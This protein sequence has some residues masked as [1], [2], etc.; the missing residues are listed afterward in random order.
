[1]AERRLN[2]KLVLLGESAVGKSSIVLRFVKSQ[3]SEY[4]E[5][6]IG[7]CVF[8]RVSV[9]GQERYH[10]LAPMYCRNAQAAIIVYD[11]TNL[12][13]FERAK[14]WVHELNERANSVKVLALAGNKL[15]L[16]S[17]RAVTTEQAQAYAT[18][19]GL[20]FMETSAKDCTNIT[21]LFTAVAL[22]LPVDTGDEAVEGQQLTAGD[23]SGPG[24]KCCR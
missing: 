1:M 17:Q 8:S 23:A 14:A 7:V 16:D 6:T 2:S 12:S 13:S 21:E 20:I 5:A 10:S 4:Q 11:I 15:D 18:E 24:H 22:R 19:N 3:F 9:H